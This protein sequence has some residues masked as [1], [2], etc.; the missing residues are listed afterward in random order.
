MTPL[1]D[2]TQAQLE[3]DTGDVAFIRVGDPVTL[4]VD[5]FDYLRFGSADGVV[6]TISEG[7]F[8]Q[9]DNGAI[10]SPFYKVW[11]EITRL[12]FHDVPENARL[13]PGMTVS[14]DIR[15]GKRTVLSY[16][17]EG[18]LRSIGEAMREP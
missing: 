15:V 11:V 4:K 3:I 13:I 9:E 17:T 7:S 12:N 18:V 5:A 2:K 14:G 8:T 10:R 16:F 6:K 1:G